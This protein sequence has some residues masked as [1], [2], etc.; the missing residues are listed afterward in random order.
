[1]S[2]FHRLILSWVT[3]LSLL[4]SCSLPHPAAGLTLPM[5]SNFSCYLLPYSDF[6]Q[7]YF[8]QK[9]LSGTPSECQAVWI[10]IRIDVLSVLI[11]VQTVCN[12]YKQTTKVTASKERVKQQHFFFWLFYYTCSDLTLSVLAVTVVII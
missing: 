1:M 2:T 10:Q 4:P 7:N 3:C 6:F 11:W 9:I 12:S 8:F 5:R